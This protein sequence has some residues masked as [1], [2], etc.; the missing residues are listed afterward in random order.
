M[1]PVLLFTL[2]LST[3]RTECGL[4]A[5][6][7]H[8]AV[9]IAGCKSYVGNKSNKRSTRHSFSTVTMGLSTWTLETKCELYGK[10]CGLLPCA[11][12]Q[13][14]DCSPSGNSPPPASFGKINIP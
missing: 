10:T 1:T 14:L 11:D 3:T 6:T 4:R 13:L 9:P 7:A 5:V 12:T 8:A 2:Q